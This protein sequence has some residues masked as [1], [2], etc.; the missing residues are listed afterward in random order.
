MAG[1]NLK[2]TEKE[3][4]DDP[5]QQM[6]TYQYVT[7]SNAAPFFSDQDSGFIEAADSMEALKKVVRE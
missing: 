7:N 3:L 4:F 1:K 6:K 5:G 2:A